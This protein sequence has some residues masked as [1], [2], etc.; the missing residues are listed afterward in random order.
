MQ[1]YNVLLHGVIGLNN[2]RGLD[3][4]GDWMGWPKFLD[5]YKKYEEAPYPETSKA[6]FLLLFEGGFRASEA[7]TITKSQCKYN[8][9]A[10][11]ISHTPVLKKKN[12]SYRDVV[13]KL[14][15]YNPLGYEFVDLINNTEGEYIFP[16]HTKFYRNII[17]DA[18]STRYTLYRRINEIGNLFPHSL[19]SYRAMM[20]VYER[21]F[22]VQDLVKWFEWTS[23]DMAVRYTR[24][25][26][27]AN[28]MGITELPM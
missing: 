19:R 16:K 1:H 17:P 21:D 5:I 22:T 27:I 4:I 9:E 25:R 15:E 8:D 13:I 6:G 11:I 10:I 2:K 7:L 14:D 12:E 18:M 20:L 23:A 28:R 24:T 3:D 26:D